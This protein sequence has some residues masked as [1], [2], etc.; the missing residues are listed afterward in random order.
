MWTACPSATSLVSRRRPSHL[1]LAWTLL[2]NHAAAYTIGWRHPPA[3]QAHTV[4]LRHLP[5]E[6]GT[7]ATVHLHVTNR[8]RVVCAETAEAAETAEITEDQPFSEPCNV[9]LTHTN[10]DFDS[11]AGAVALAKVW[12]V[13]RPHVPTH[14]VMPRGVNPLVARFLAYHKHLLPIRGFKTIRKEDIEAVGVVDTQSKDRLGPAASWLGYAKHVS[15]YDHHS[16]IQGDI[17]PTELHVEAVG[18]ATTLLC[19]RLKNFTE[20]PVP[21]RPELLLSEAEATLFALGIRADTGALSYP[22]TTPRD[23]HALVWLM[24]QGMSQVAIAEFGQARLSAVQRDLLAL[25]MERIEHIE[26]EGTKIGLVKMDTGRGFVTGMSAIAEELLQLMSLDVILL[27]VLHRD[28][29]M[30]SFLSIIGRRSGRASSVD[31]NQI[32]ARWHGGGHPAAAA[33][34]VRVAT[35]VPQQPELLTPPP[36]EAEEE[37][38]DCEAE[39]CAVEEVGAAKAAKAATSAQFVYFSGEGHSAS[40]ADELRSGAVNDEEAQTAALAADEA[41]SILQSALTE[42]LTAIPKQVTASKLMTK[43]IF[44]CAPNDTMTHALLLM[45]RVEKKATP[46]VDP[47]TGRLCGMLKFRDVVKAAQ[48]GKGRQ[49]V[50]AWMRREVTTVHEDTTFTDLEQALQEQTGRLPVVDHEGRLQGLVTRTDVL[51]H[52]KLYGEATRRRVA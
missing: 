2:I 15:V 6:L 48:A 11:L 34:S 21:G 19:E 31:L 51:R 27:G 18:S 16:G 22:D 30:N 42:V 44:S 14:V 25:G 46:V 36:E 41:S 50:K 32:L 12:S 33:A 5:G 4:G 47:K 9:V 17:N 20:N 23:G 45:R 38:K 40:P 13:T 7:A 52:H 35:I 26:H 29:K 8:A 10:A 37:V 24:E 39:E 3:T 49:Q 43:T 1:L 28:R